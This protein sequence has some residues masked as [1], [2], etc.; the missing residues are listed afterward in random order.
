[1]SRPTTYSFAAYCTLILLLLQ[2][3]S[4]ATGARN[5]PITAPAMAL[6]KVTWE[7]KVLQVRGEIRIENTN[8]GPSSGIGHKP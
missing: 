3:L 1:M 6:K 7:E 8:P 2:L 5:I 4:Q